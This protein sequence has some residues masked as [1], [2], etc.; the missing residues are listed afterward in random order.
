MQFPRLYSPRRSRLPIPLHQ[1]RSNL[2]IMRAHR[3]L[4]RFHC[5]RNVA[6]L[7]FLTPNVRRSD[8]FHGKLIGTG[9]LMPL[10]KSLRHHDL[11]S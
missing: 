7:P 10:V 8:D 5:V 2:M 11:F 4:F 1:P 3:G 9:I 6:V